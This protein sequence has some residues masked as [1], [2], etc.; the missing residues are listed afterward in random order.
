[1][2]VKGGPG[3]WTFALKNNFVN[4][5]F[6]FILRK[7]NIYVY[8]FWMKISTKGRPDHITLQTQSVIFPRECVYDYV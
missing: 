4:G 6:Y 2:L 7:N 1:M 5:Q 8:K 3:I